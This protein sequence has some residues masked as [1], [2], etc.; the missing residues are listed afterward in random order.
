MKRFMKKLI[1]ILLLTLSTMTLYGVDL[2]S[3]NN[4]GDWSNVRTWTDDPSG[5]GTFFHRIPDANDNII[6]LSGSVV[7]YTG[8][9]YEHFGNVIIENN[10]SLIM[11]IGSQSGNS[12]TYSGNRFENYG[13]FEVSNDFIVNS[14]NTIFKQNT[15]AKI[16]NDLIIRPSAEI[17]IETN[18]CDGFIVYDD[19]IL[20]GTNSSIT[21]DGNIIFMNSDVSIIGDMDSGIDVYTDMRYSSQFDIDTNNV[22]IYNCDI[23]FYS[24]NKNSICGVKD[25]F[26]IYAGNNIYV[27]YIVVEQTYDDS[28]TVKVF[29]VNNWV[30][31]KMD[32]HIATR[33]ADIPLNNAG[34][35]SIGN[36]DYAYTFYGN[37]FEE[38][39]YT[40]KDGKL[41]IAIHF[42]VENTIFGGSEETAWAG[43]KP[44]GKNWSLYF[45]YCMLPQA[46]PVD[47]IHFKQE[48]EY[49]V[50]VTAN[51]VNNEGFYV[52][53]SNDG[54]VW[55]NEDFIYGFG[56]TNIEQSYRWKITK[57]GYYRLKQIDYDGKY[58]YS[59]IIS[60]DKEEVITF[61]INNKII[62][63]NKS[64]NVKLM[65]ISGQILINDNVSSIDANRY[66]NGVYILTIEND[67]YKIKI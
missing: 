35:A 62:S 48:G 26:S 60:V 52:Q 46:L 16:C 21:G 18:A 49:L 42:V 13:H 29:L 44:L 50:W 24:N 34:N 5:K 47:L 20:E 27:G 51:E 11:N 40:D 65:N 32:L 3:R 23:S 43:D 64:A 33:K 17:E 58:E 4:G 38:T 7:T 66:P 1:S 41:Y 2:Y 63:L 22:F 56:T 31:K 30:A 54:Y 14:S 67:L 12:F 28:V 8:I 10:A 9:S 55:N 53:N 61:V 19:I 57:S 45:E 15:T 6:I 37:Y 59:N 36:F 39:Y 25:T